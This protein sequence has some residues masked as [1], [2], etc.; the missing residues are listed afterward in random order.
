MFIFSIVSIWLDLIERPISTSPGTTTS[1]SLP[2]SLASSTPL[3]LPS[4]SPKGKACGNRVGYTIAVQVTHIT[5][6]NPHHGFYHHSKAPMPT[7]EKNLDRLYLENKVHFR[8]AIGSQPAHHLNQPNSPWL[9]QPISPLLSTHSLNRLRTRSLMVTTEM[10]MLWRQKNA[11]DIMLTLVQKLTRAQSAEGC[12]FWKAKNYV[13]RE[14]LAR[15]PA[16]RGHS[17]GELLDYYGY[18]KCG[19]DRDEFA[20]WSGWDEVTFVAIKYYFLQVYSIF[21]IKRAFTG[22]KTVR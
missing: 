11:R 3:V 5:S 10:L 2:A 17:S 18:G 22:K 19:Q 4:A 1:V 9:D 13:R 6:S 15:L 16:P 7:V 14:Y 8:C 20:G 21:E 12:Y